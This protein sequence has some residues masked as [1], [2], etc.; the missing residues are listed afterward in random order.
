M[1]FELEWTFKLPLYS[2]HFFICKLCLPKTELHS[3]LYCI[4]C[5][6]AYFYQFDLGC[7][8]FGWEGTVSKNNFIVQTSGCFP[9]IVNTLF[10]VLKHSYFP[11][12]YINNIHSF[13]GESDILP[14][15]CGRPSRSKL[16]GSCL[17]FF[18]FVDILPFLPFSSSIW[19]KNI[20]HL[21]VFINFTLIFILKNWAVM[22]TF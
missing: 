3:P 5:N 11:F 10:T 15:T 8:S 16:E 18:T 7:C 9:K 6:F 19:T 14:F 21:F 13:S 4:N 17:P 2:L 20:I 1:K 22:K 12:C